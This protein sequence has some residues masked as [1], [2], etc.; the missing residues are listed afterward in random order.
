MCDCEF[1]I[2]ESCFKICTCCGN[3]KQVLN[4]DTYNINSAPLDVSYSR[5]YRFKMKFERLVGLNHPPSTDDVW[6]YLQNHRLYLNDPFDIRECLKMSKLKCKHYDCVRIFCNVFTDFKCP[7]SDMKGTV[8]DFLNVAN[9]AFSD[10]YHAWLLYDG[11]R[12]FSYDWLIRQYC[13]HEKSP[14]IIYLKPETSK[15]RHAM[16]VT[17]LKNII[18]SQHNYGMSSHEKL[19]NRFLNE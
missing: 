5:S 2:I 6:K 16:Y 19:I 4:L 7:H 11:S 3:T 18:Q 12:F 10:L 15:K 9:K 8:H 14:L 17:K 1:S 13:E